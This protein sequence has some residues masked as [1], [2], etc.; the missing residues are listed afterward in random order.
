MFIITLGLVGGSKLLVSTIV[1][2]KNIENRLVATQLAQEAL[3]VV[4]NMRDTNY[5]TY[6]ANARECWNYWDDTDEDGNVDGNDDACNPN[7]S[8]QS[9]HAWGFNG[10]NTFVVTPDFDNFRWTLVRVVDLTAL[11]MSERLHRDI[12]STKSL[13]DLHT[14]DVIGNAPT[15]FS[16]TVELRYLDADD[17]VST[18]NGVI[19]GTFPIA[20]RE[21]DNRILVISRVT[22]EDRGHTKEI[23][24]TTLLTDFFDREG[25]VE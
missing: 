3:E 10:N 5:L 6:A 8:G 20:D 7:P 11:N 24:L 19:G 16:R 12:D 17:F 18:A 2:N 14:H 15:E 9:D 25:W 23:V 1:A 13:P 4:R 21:K 22:W